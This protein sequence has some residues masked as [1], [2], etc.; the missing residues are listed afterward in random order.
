[1]LFIEFQQNLNS[2]LNI[3]R[4]RNVDDESWYY[5]YIDIETLNLLILN[6]GI[7]STCRN[8]TKYICCDNPSTSKTISLKYCGSEIKLCCGN[9]DSFYLPYLEQNY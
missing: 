4:Y 5:L 9:K 8:P 2:G 3:L 1:M 6:F 7:I